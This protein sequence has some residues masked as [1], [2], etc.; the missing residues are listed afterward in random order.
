VVALKEALVRLLKNTEERNR[1][2]EAARHRVTTE[3]SSE[4]AAQRVLGLFQ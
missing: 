4:M 1:L 3:F 2:G